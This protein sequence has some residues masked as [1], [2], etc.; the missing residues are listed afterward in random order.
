MAVFL[1][2]EVGADDVRGLIIPVRHNVPVTGRIIVCQSAGEINVS[3]MRVRLRTAENFPVGSPNGRVA[4]DGTFAIES[5]SQTNRRVSLTGLPGGAYVAAA[6]IG[7]SDIL[8]DGIQVTADLGPIEFWV[9]G[10]GGALDGTVRITADQTY[11]GAQ[12]V[13][14]P[15]DPERND[16]YK[17]ASVDQYGRFAMGG[18]APVNYSVFAWEDAPEGAF[19]DPDFAGLYEDFCERIEIEQSGHSQVQPQLIPAG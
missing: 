15:E 8:G 3:R 16:L 12:A 9:S 17:V 2:I 4:D 18:I 13:L 19:Q 11:T 1:D 7:G 10:A 6:Y 14:I 5:V